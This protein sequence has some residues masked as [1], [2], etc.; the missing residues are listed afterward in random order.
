[1]KRLVLILL[2]PLMVLAACSH[3]Q[4]E[5][6]LYRQYAGRQ[7]LTA[8]Q[9]NGFR[10]NDTVTVDVVFLVA[11]D[12]AA[13]QRLKEEMDI[14]ATEGVTSWLGDIDEPARRVKRDEVPLWRAMAVHDEKTVAFY[15]VEN[16][17]QFAALRE[18][19]MDRMT[20]QYGH[21]MVTL[22]GGTLAAGMYVYSL[23]VDGQIVDTKQMILTK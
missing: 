22:S 16:A 18:Y 8:A 10:L 15:R 4:E 3:K 23:V 17:E 7:D 9:V 14:R 20:K 13:W 12:S 2:L 5:L 1:M 21:G 11:D 19:Q 6:P